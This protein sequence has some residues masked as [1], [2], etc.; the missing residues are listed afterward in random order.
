MKRKSNTQANECM[1]AQIV[2]ILE[3][4]GAISKSQIAARLS[5]VTKPT[6][7]Q[8]LQ[9]QAP[10]WA[11][12][13]VQAA[14]PDVQGQERTLLLDA[15]G[16][17]FVAATLLA[18]YALQRRKAGKTYGKLWKSLLAVQKHALETPVK[19]GWEKKDAAFSPGDSDEADSTEADDQWVREEGETR[20]S[21]APRSK[22]VGAL[23]IEKSA[24][25]SYGFLVKVAD[26]FEAERTRRENR[27]QQERRRAERRANGQ[28]KHPQ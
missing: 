6:L 4:E 13:Y 18:C 3:R 23:E 8:W 2:A 17:S 12:N 16:S 24:S 19:P 26:R 11:V 7:R 21:P 28:S 22:I 27:E 20:P 14:F 15:S 10:E 5:G 25:I 1:E 9:F